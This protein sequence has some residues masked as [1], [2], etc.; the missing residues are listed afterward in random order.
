MMV[1]CLV[2]WLEAAAASEGQHLSQQLL[3]LLTKLRQG[4][5]RRRDGGADDGG[6]ALRDAARELI[7]GW[8]L[9]DASPQPHNALLEHIARYE[10]PGAALDGGDAAGVDRVITMALEIDAMGPDVLAAADRAIDD[11][12]L[13]VLLHRVERAPTRGRTYEALVAHLHAPAMVRRMLLTE[14]VDYDAARALLE[15]CDLEQLPAMLDALAVS[16]SQSTRQLILARVRAFGDAAR[17]ALL[18]RLTPTAPWPITRNLLHLLVFTPTAPADVPLRPYLQ[19]AEAVVRMEALRLAARLPAERDRALADAV[20]DADPRVLRTVLELLADGVPRRAVPR[21]LARLQA[22]PKG[23]E[24]RVRGLPLLAAQPTT[25]ARDFLL[26][27]VARRTAIRRRLVLLDKSLE[28]LAA[29]R[30]LAVGWADDPV[31]R[32]LLA[33]AAQDADPA[34]RDAARATGPAR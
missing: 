34:V 14:L 16:E 27:L 1:S 31:V 15:T 32:E 28:S 8:D 22:E 30:A 29:L 6:E 25:T 18:D 26:E 12:R 3:R 21:L 11:R 4:A 33:L 19:H 23:A 10:R 2:E 17:P 13:G 20:A 9:A 5:R 7:A 24:S